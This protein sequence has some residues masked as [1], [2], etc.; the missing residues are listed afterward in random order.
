M[1]ADLDRQRLAQSMFSPRPL[2]EV[3]EAIALATEHEHLLYVER[4][5]AGWRWSLAHKG[6]GYPLL[7]IYARFLQVDHHGLYIG[8]EGLDSGLTI[9]LGKDGQSAKGRQHA[10]LEFG[11]ATTPTEAKRRITEAFGQLEPAE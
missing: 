3:A 5:D 6:G 8:F 1:S 2:D 9:A 11:H 4:T 10:L 7:R